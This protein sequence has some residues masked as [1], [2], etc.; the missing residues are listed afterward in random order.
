MNGHEFAEGK[1]RHKTVAIVVVVGVEEEAAGGSRSGLS[2][3]TMATD[4][5]Y[6]AHL[7]DRGASSSKGGRY[8]GNGV[9]GS[10]S[11]NSA[12]DGF[13]PRKVNGA[14]TVKAMVRVS[15]TFVLYAFQAEP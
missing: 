3:L 1:A 6:L 12:L 8:M 9:N 7:N 5:P 13:V 14:Q 10:S 4:N 15:S 11:S 2:L